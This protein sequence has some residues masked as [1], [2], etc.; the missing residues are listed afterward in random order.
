[1]NNFVIVESKHT[2]HTLTKHQFV[3]YLFIQQSFLQ[4]IFYDMISVKPNMYMIF[5]ITEGNLSL[6]SLRSGRSMRGLFYPELGGLGTLRKAP[7][8]KRQISG[9]LDIYCIHMKA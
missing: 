5:C 7:I 9:W 2:Q 1:M 4:G 8:V 6:S 3:C